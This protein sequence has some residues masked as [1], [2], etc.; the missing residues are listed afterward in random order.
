MAIRVAIAEDQRL[1]RE[2]L[3]ALLA[4]EPGIT[5][6]GEASTGREAIELV[7]AKRPDV[8]VLDISLPKLDGIEV[9]RTLLLRHPELKVLA[10]SVHNDVDVVRRMLK[11]GAVG[12]VH[13]S[14]ALSELVRAIRDVMQNNI[15]LSP[16]ITRQ[17]LGERLGAAAS[18]DLLSRRERQ[19][20]ALI[21][22][23][24]RS[25]EIAERLKISIATVEVH[26]RNIMRKLGLHTV[27]ELT[28]YAVR[29]GLTSL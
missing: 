3:G 1:V 14:A 13:K 4:R 12:Y 23:G 29:E 10:L 18:R 21:A 5:V 2:A 26:R 25:S 7:Q 22:E 24:K 19:V 9:A 20:L 28:R 6:V 11:A 27:A 15:Y 16:R 17:A 8:L